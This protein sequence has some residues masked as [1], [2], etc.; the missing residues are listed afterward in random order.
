VEQIRLSEFTIERIQNRE[1]EKLIPELYE[2][3]EIIE[4]NPW[5]NNDNVLNHTISLLREL[6]ELIK[7][8]ND[9]IKVY[10]DK[11]INTYSRRKLLFL[12]AL[13][14]DIGK[15]ETYKKEKDITECLGHEE[16]GAVKLKTIL[17]RFNLSEN[18]E[19]FVI[20]IV[21]NH[22]V[23]HEILNYPDENPEKKTEEFKK[24]HPEVFLEIIILAIADMLGSQL[25]DNR[26]EEFNFRMGFLNKII[27]NY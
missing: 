17:P 5:H 1:F 6:E 2:L 20:K 19:E 22:G 8:P 25:K 4:N 16:V 18:E 7:K 9:K 21:R 15:K 14:H 27:D 10:L 26:P 13:L 12:A 23:I 3:E 24:R 11:K